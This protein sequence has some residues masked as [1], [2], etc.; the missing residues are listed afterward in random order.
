MPIYTS[1]L[2][3][4]GLGSLS[5]LDVEIIFEPSGPS[6]S[7][8]GLHAARPILVRPAADG[9]FS[10]NLIATETMM[11]AAWYVMRFRWR[12]PSLTGQAGFVA[13]DFPEFRLVTAAGGGDLTKW[14]NVPF[15]NLLMVI[16][17]PAPPDP[18]P[19]GAIWLNTGSGDYFRRRA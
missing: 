11:P 19:I 10:V 9:S 8:G 3:D 15:D 6:V 5:A 4:F 1:K 12:E 16:T 13:Y 2:T 14:L 7:S 17:E 18:W